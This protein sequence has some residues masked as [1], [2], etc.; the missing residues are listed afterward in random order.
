MGNSKK[1]TSPKQTSS[2]EVSGA[3]RGSKS[4][5][6]TIRLGIL[7]DFGANAIVMGSDLE[8]C[9][10]GR[11]STGSITL[12]L[13][14]GGGVPIGRA[15][16]ISGARSS[17][18]T[19]L[20]NHIAK[21][22]QEKVAKWVYTRRAYE[23]GLEQV[24]E[25]PKEQHGLICGY[26]DVEGTQDVAWLNQIGVNTDD[27]WLYN[28]SAGMEEA[29][30]L[31][32][33]M[34]LNGVNVIF[35]DSVDSLEPTLYYET[36]AKDSAR[37][38]VKQTAMGGFLRKF[39]ATNNKLVREGKLPCTLILLNQL[40]EKIGAYG[41]PEYTPGGRAIEFYISIDLRLRRGDWI[42]VGSGE[43]KQIIGQVTKFK[44]NKNKTY[45]QQRTGEFD[46]YFDDSE[47]V[48]AGHIDNAKEIVI[49]GIIWGVIEKA[50]AWFKYKGVNIAQGADNTVAKVLDDEELY[51]SIKTDLF[52]LVEKDVNRF[53]E[54]GEQEEKAPKKK[55][56]KK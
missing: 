8:K 16:Q 1:K 22:A 34:Q 27:K 39:T 11:I 20:C 52:D 47:R 38:G 25:T 7:K 29:F 36:D 21:N 19:S 10:Y 49:N 15:I 41:D 5:T 4:V 54:E 51:E 48:Q 37:M 53:L 26:I 14:M 2:G 17:G 45:K 3:S 35:M 56:G 13:E 43:D 23:K 28:Q 40:R 46:F 18:K 9:N 31:S 42:S 30:D 6:D 32:H 24:T 55:G 12:D 33:Y 44:T 50:G